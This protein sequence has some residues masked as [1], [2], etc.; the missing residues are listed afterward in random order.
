MN[1]ICD[2]H[3]VEQYAEGNPN[4]PASYAKYYEDN[5]YAYELLNLTDQIEFFDQYIRDRRCAYVKGAMI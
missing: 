5:D 4:D 3:H 1:K 2:Y